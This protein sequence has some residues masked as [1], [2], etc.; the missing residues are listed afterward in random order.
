M[1]A[2]VISPA[3]SILGYK[4]NEYFEFQPSATNSPVSWAAVG[5]PAGLSINS[6]TGLISGAATTAGV[7]NVTVTATASDATT[8]TAT[9]VIGINSEIAPA[10]ASADIST[11][12]NFDVVSRAL[13]A[14]GGGGSFSSGTPGAT[15]VIAEWKSDDIFLLR[16]RFLKNGQIID[17]N[18]TALKLIIKEN[19]PE[20]SI[21]LDTTFVKT[22]TGDGAYFD[23]LVDLSDASVKNTLSSYDADAGTSFTALVEI[24][25]ESSL[26]FG[27]SSRTLRLSSRTASVRVSRDFVA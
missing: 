16:L 22:G 7:R 15:P 19:E 18:P 27:G 13:A 3:Q 2:P 10:A 9:F 26:T 12:W 6:T 24:Q 20:N 4:R 14:L 5:L 17:P 1:P 8:G 11:E 25:M 23:L 21:S